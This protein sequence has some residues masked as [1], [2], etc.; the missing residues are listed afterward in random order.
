MAMS[1]ESALIPKVF[2][3][4]NLESGNHSAKKLP[5]SV[6]IV[7]PESL[8]HPF[9]KLQP[10]KIKNKSKIFSTSRRIRTWGLAD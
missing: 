9:K 1:R 8:E 10:N 6:I 4:P 5:A 3:T 2:V 7:V